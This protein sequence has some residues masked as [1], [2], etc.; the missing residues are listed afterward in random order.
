MYDKSTIIQD[1]INEATK[2]V[3]KDRKQYDKLM[4]IV[5][6]FISEN[7]IIVKSNDN[8][9]F[10][11]YTNDI[12]KLPKTLVDLLYESDPILAKYI[13]LLTRIYKYSYKIII[14]GI[15]FIQFTY[16]NQ[17]IRN[18][19]L[20]IQICGKFSNVQYNSFGPEIQLISIYS[21]L[22]NPTLTDK[23][24]ELYDKEK[25]LSIDIYNTFK[26]KILGGGE[27]IEN[28]I[29][30]IL[31]NFITTKHVIVG[32]LGMLIYQKQKNINVN[33]I[34]LVTENTLNDEI[35]ILKSLI[36]NISYNINNLRL[37]I[38]LNYH[39]ISF[40]ITINNK[41]KTFLDIYDVGNYEPIPFLYAHEI[42]NKSNIKEDFQIGSLFILKKFRLI[43]I[44][45]TMY[46][47]NTNYINKSDFDNIINKLIIDYQILNEIKIRNIK[48]LFPTN[49]IG[50]LEDVLLIKERVANKLKI[51]YIP[52]YMPFLEKKQI[53]CSQLNKYMINY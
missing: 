12:F 7:D 3:E 28:T 11:L 10:E 38:N 40:S 1:T 50:F 37:P 53:S 45:N 13:T 6:K 29:N 36:P 26:P 33:R 5:E 31:N 16:I 35:N 20:C 23:W 48:L 21:N 2:I 25:I 43:D 8:Y 46:M 24:I 18:N 19:I 14:N 49:Y 47:L 34:Q 44:W 17:E 4:K 32:Q 52:P 41:K 9:Y 42:T 39:K 27:N 15:T 30:F 22:T 51:K